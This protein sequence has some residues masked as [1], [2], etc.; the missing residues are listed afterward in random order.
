MENVN[1]KHWNQIYNNKVPTEVSWYQ[2]MP[3]LSLSLIKELGRTASNVLDIG[4]GA[5]SLVDN[6][7]DKTNSKSNYEVGLVDIANSAFVHTKKRLSDRASEAFFIEA[8]VTKP[9]VGIEENW[10]DVWH[11]RAVFHF[12]TKPEQ[13]IGYANNISNLVNLNGSI[14]IATFSLDG[15]EKCSGLEVNRYDGNGIQQALAEC[16]LQLQ[17]DNEVQFEHGTP[18]G[19]IQQF[20]YAVLTLLP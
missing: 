4:A 18:W 10:A 3:S 9:I 12:L 19:T 8:D 5:S 17:L 1:K 16:G 6:L 13:R 20:T 15:P 2:Q 11:D 14:I 7:L